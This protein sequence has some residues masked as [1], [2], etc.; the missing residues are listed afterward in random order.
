[1]II[2]T[3]YD[4]WFF[5]EVSIKHYLHTSACKIYD[6]YVYETKRQSAFIVRNERQIKISLYYVNDSESLVYPG[7][8]PNAIHC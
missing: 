3:D 1:M 4:F 7:I 6:Q 8:R 2:L 5:F